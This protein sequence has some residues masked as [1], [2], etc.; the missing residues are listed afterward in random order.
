MLNEIAPRERRQLQ[1]DLF[2]NGFD[3]LSGR[4]H[5][6]DAFVPGTVFGLRQQIGRDVTGISG[7][8]R[9]HE[10]FTRTRR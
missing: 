2:F 8:I 6:P 3:E 1:G 4:R 5:E 7:V 10:H 9:Q